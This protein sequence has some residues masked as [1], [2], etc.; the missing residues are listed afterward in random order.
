MA[1][2]G[3]APHAQRAEQEIRQRA[4]LTLVLESRAVES[5]ERLAAFRRRGA[6]RARKAQVSGVYFEDD[7]HRLRSRKLSLGVIRSARGYVQA[8]QAKHL[9]I[10]P[11]VVRRE[12]MGPVPTQDPVVSAFGDRAIRSLMPPRKGVLR[13]VV[14]S[15]VERTTRR[16]EFPDGGAVTVDVDLG[17]TNTDSSQHPVHE[18]TLRLDSGGFD[19]LFDLAL[20]LREV[21]PF[22]LSTETWV[23]RALAR[24][25]E[26][27]PAS[28]KSTRLVLPRN[29]NVAEA[30]TKIVQHCL[31]HLLANEACILASEDT[32]GVHQM[33]VALRRLRS[34]LRTFRPLLPADQV[35][36]LNDEAKFLA[37]ELAEARDWDVFDEE[38]VAPLA[39]TF[40]SLDDFHVFR[41][42]IAAER[43]RS[44]HKARDAVRSD[45]YTRFL[46]EVGAWITR[47][48]WQGQGDGE[49]AGQLQGPLADF[50]NATLDKQHRRVCKAGRQFENLP[51]AERHQMRIDVKRLRYSSDF[52]G[53]LYGRK[54]VK[55]YGRYLAELQDALGY[56]NDVAVAQ[57][58]VERLCAST[59]GRSTGQCRLA[60]GMVIGWHSHVLAASEPRLV[61]NVKHFLDSTPYWSQVRRRPA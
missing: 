48:G 56:L 7:G 18:I 13:P 30:L 10:G 9:Q 50:S 12:W 37:G 1:R 59:K 33:R 52:F 14:R 53:S 16:L 17:E 29:A 15:C 58:L 8:L 6:G 31:E 20:E 43:Q 54:A 57:E 32:E 42:R 46:L 60:G 21:L 45:R 44:R 22:S 25:A 2:Q 61:E 28:H 5:L 39:S 4:A 23:E 36:R 24:L 34:A 38:L 47:Q 26:E 55:A 49:T 27:T 51:I 3:A 11:A 35:K 19:R 41:A 40:E